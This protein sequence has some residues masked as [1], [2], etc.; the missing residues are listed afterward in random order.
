MGFPVQRWLALPVYRVRQLTA[1]EREEAELFV[2]DELFAAHPNVECLT[3]GWIEHRLSTPEL[4]VVSV[5]AMGE[6]PPCDRCQDRGRLLGSEGI[7]G[8]W[9]GCPLGQKALYDAAAAWFR[10]PVDPTS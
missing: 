1:T 8:A 3:V 9:C 5:V 6:L 7:N 4:G 10:Q 2:A